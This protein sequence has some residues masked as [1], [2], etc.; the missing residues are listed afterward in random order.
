M[1]VGECGARHLDVALEL[2]ERR[3]E[4]EIPEMEGMRGCRVHRHGSMRTRAPRALQ[5]R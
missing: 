4:V 5:K 1:G 2:R 3:W